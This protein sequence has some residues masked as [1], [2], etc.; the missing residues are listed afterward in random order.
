[1]LYYT[2][3]LYIY[4]WDRVANFGSDFEA[5]VGYM[6]STPKIQIVKSNR[7][8]LIQMS[9]RLDNFAIHEEVEATRLC[10]GLC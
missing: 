5:W 3:V 4:I 9:I 8:R 10:G 1:M 2:I 7:I 6:F